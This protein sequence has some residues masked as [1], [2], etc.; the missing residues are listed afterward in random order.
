VKELGN[1]NK[2]LQSSA[3]KN[4]A[5]KILQRK[6]SLHDILWFVSKQALPEMMLVSMLF[7]ENH[8]AE[9]EDHRKSMICFYTFLWEFR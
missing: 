1:G 2:E 7:V 9:N 4:S 6:V 8:I 5:L 3:A